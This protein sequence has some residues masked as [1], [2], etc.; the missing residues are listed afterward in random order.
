[1]QTLSRDT[2]A[3][4]E[5]VQLELLRRMPPWRKLE[6][7]EE[8]TRTVYALLLTGLRERYPRATEQELRLRMAALVLGP[9]LATRVYGP[10]PEEEEA[11]GP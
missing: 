6:L 7:A 10:L 1:M 2:S 9:E 3:D 11:D 4:A 5:R 8:M